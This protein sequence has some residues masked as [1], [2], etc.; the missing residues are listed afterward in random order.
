MKLLF[1]CTGNTCRSPMAMGLARKHFPP[2]IQICS[3]GIHAWDG[4]R[5]SEQAVQALKKQEID[6]SSHRANKL[7]KDMLASADY[8]F[9][10][11]VAQAQSLKQAYPEYKEK[12]Y[13][14]GVWVGSGKEVPDPIG[15]S[16]EIYCS[17]AQELE[18]MIKAAA[19]QLTGRG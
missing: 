6:I 7:T 1:V 5:V 2:E 12:I 8:V 15:G 10:M 3:A 13:T 16:F 17:C 14:L 19:K 9:T 11:T 4:Q 18:Q